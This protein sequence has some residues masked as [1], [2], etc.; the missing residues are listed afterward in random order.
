MNDAKS[1]PIDQVVLDTS[2]PRIKQFLEM[3][4]VPTEE[5]MLLAL[6]AG[7]DEEGGNDALASFR[8][9]KHSIIAS[10]GIIQ[11]IIVKPVAGE[12][13]LCVEGNTRVAIY[14]QLRNESQTRDD[15][16]GQW[17]ELPAI[18]DD[19]MDED[20]AHRV[21]LQVHLV[22]PRPWDPY[23]KA[24]YLNELVS[25]Y[26]MP[27]DR[28]VALCGGSERD[29]RQS[30][31]AYHD[32]ETHYRPVVEDDSHSNFD[33]SRFS[34]FVELQK[35]GIKAALYEA[36][37]DERDFSKWVDDRNLRPLQTIRKLPQILANSQAKRIFLRDGA[38]AAILALEAP[39]LDTKLREATIP[40]LARAL[41]EKL[42]SLSFD[43]SE[44]IKSDDQADDYLDLLDL[45]KSINDILGL[46]TVPSY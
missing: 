38:K 28:L 14:R 17:D 35:P 19:Q 11:P 46:E 33:P 25:D 31:D 24:K 20:A 12:Q 41:Q 37:Y 45:A 23:S 8:R 43:Q 18:V 30:I 44:A 10:G 13:Y 32:I 3:Y 7:A 39:D 9:L 16:L 27:Y 6:G 1:I 21:R 34:A 40:Q 29:I 26:K 5:Q 42:D 4:D 15:Y 22:G 2:N 36:G